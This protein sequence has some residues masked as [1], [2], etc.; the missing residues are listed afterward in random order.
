[1]NSKFI[2]LLQRANGWKLWTG[3]MLVALLTVEVIVALL[4][5]LFYG[6]VVSE[7]L[8]E[9][10]VATAIVEP[11]HLAFM[12]YLLGEFSKSQ[13]H[14]LES[15]VAYA[16]QRFRVAVEISQLN[17]WEMNLVTNEI[18]Y[19]DEGLR[20]LGIQ[21][22]H[23]PHDMQSWLAFVHPE[24]RASLMAQFQHALQPGSA[25][26]DFEY[27]IAHPGGLWGWA[28]TR[29]E[30]AKRDAA[31]NPLWAVGSTLNVTTRKNAEIAL[32]EE[33]NRFEIIFNNTPELMLI[34]RLSDGCIT[35]ANDAA[36]RASGYSREE[37]IGNTTVNLGV[38]QR[39][40][41]RQRM[42]D[43][44]NQTGHCHNIE[45]E[46][47]AKNGQVFIGSV[48]AVVT[49]LDGVPHIVSTVRDVTERKR[50]ETELQRSETLL[51]STLESTDEGILMIAQDGHV[52]SANKRFMELWRVPKYLVDTG[53]DDLL[54]AHVLEQL[55]DP[56]AFLHQVRRL[57]N[58]YEEA[59]DVLHF[60][61][62]RV[63]ARFTRALSVDEESGRIWCFKDITEEARTQ[64]ALVEREEMFRSIFAQASDGIWL[65]DPEDKRIIEFNDAACADLGYSRAE[66]AKF[67]IK[68]IQ[69]EY[70]N[71][72]IEQVSQ[73]ILEAGGLQFDTLH[74]HKNGSTRVVQVSSKPIRLHGKQY[75]VSLVSD[76]TE[77]KRHEELLRANEQKM[78]TILDNVDAFIYLK[79]IQ[80]NYLFANRRVRELWQV[81]MPDIVGYG[82][83]KFFDAATAANIRNND[84]RV[85]QGGEILKAEE[86]NTVPATGKTFTYLSTKLPLRNEDGSI[87]ALCGI[88]T[89]I[90]ERIEAE[91]TLRESES[92][93]HRA[94]DA[95]QMGVWEFDFVARKLYWSEEIFRHL[96]LAHVEPSPE[97]LRTLIHP[98]DND[99]RQQAMSKAV[100]ERAAYFAVYRL[101]VNGKTYWTE[102]RGELQYDA[103]GNPLKMIGTAQDITARKNIEQALAE[104]EASLRA[105][106][107]VAGLGTYS[108]DIQTGVWKSSAVLDQLLGIDA[109]Y[110]HSVTGWENLIHAEDRAMMHDYFLHEVIGKKSDFQ[111]EYRIVR[112]ADNVVRWVFGLGRLE[113][114]KAG[115]PSKMFGT[116]QDITARK[117]TEA[118]LLIAATAF[119][120]QEG[121]MVTD[122]HKNILKVNAAFTAI[123][124]YGAE[125]VIGKNP[126]MLASGLQDKNFYKAMWDS[127][128][129]HG[130]WKGELLNR[131]KSGEIYPELLMITAVKDKAGKVSHYV[132]AQSDNS[133]RQMVMEQLRSAAVNLEAVNRQV[134][135]ERALLAQRVEERTSQLRYANRAKDSFLATM[136]HEI[137]TPLGGLLGMMELL[138]MS[139]L[140][141]EQ[142]QMLT[143][144]RQSG[145]SLLRIVDD[146]LD[147]S[148]IEA[149]KL[150][151]APQVASVE[152]M[153]K[154]VVNTYA[155]L[156]AAKGV[157]LKLDIQPGGN[158]H[159]YFDALR[160]SQ[161]LNNFTSNA[162]KFT[163]RGTVLIKLDWLGG[164]HG[165]DT[166]RFSVKDNGIGIA[167]EQQERLFHHYEQASA[168][169]ARMYGGTGLGL[170]ICRSLADLL[171]G[172]I[173]V[174]S[175][176]N[177]GST[178]SFSISLPVANVA[179]DN[180]IAPLAQTEPFAPLITKGQKVSVLVVDDHPMNRMLLK[181]QLALLGLGVEVSA[182]G[183]EAL[184]LW[185][186][187]KYD[188]IITDCHMPEMDGYELTRRIRQ[189]E[190]ET[191]ATR[192][193]IIAW[194]A[195]ALA[196]E[197]ANCQQAGMDDL[198]TKPTELS[199]LK[200]MLSKW[201]GKLMDTATPDVDAQPAAGEPP[202]APAIVTLDMN[203][204]RKIS[205]RH[206]AQVELLSEFNKENRI[207]IA[208]LKTALQVGDEVAAARNAHRVK[209]ASRMVGAL[210][211][212]EIC[213]RIEQLAKQEDMA[214]ARA[215]AENSLDEVMRNLE[216]AIE[217]IIRMP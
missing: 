216:A 6:H 86:T 58:S 212:E 54:L 146:I 215:A 168:D 82:D 162:I 167:P 21:A 171:G 70:D 67:S 147:W 46:V 177:A 207:D 204:L 107:R 94:L 25:N 101:L 110:E 92:R 10:L 139:H 103:Q 88:S 66:F 5:V 132:G 197:V 7:D 78:L 8:I 41:D 124:G 126:R 144:A 153:L 123:T 203:V 17:V 34:S 65:I 31:G 109:R 75:L 122:A 45:V 157:E 200:A 185:Q 161:I 155:Q 96:G 12:I 76:I 191:S 91:H 2:A 26:F 13:I 141:I 11:T 159:H 149:K 73:K 106:Q 193:P 79:D 59:R 208:N 108:L 143:A 184:S 38:W 213:T 192:L 133:E 24:D 130:V 129:T 164:Y 47:T 39:A 199:A 36:V 198:M 32:Q 117:E 173:E 136:S 180:T 52:L 28:H 87:Y 169:T 63:F 174:E 18:I 53:K 1:M 74:K 217:K 62:G 43:A 81:E 211:L 61:D 98:D 77:R 40:E 85:L 131:R 165:F 121:L 210:Q 64:T 4:D 105:S 186:A 128:N 22:D 150:V 152:D 44:L 30:I 99:I 68:D 55:V 196:D 9:G 51:R 84:C 37:I 176:P 89:D 205:V 80:G 134:E 120:S 194:T 158:S 113:W 3:V 125:E 163:E 20:V 183:G 178:F 137:R 49:S 170:S 156:A 100:S 14:T 69:A 90:T 140:D 71:Q 72:Q 202:V 188:L 93:L 115:N 83:E 175:A 116:I 148:K 119:E 214:N 195:N 35:H 60:K 181:Q 42:L 182:D 50:L 145:K 179:R 111:K 57:Y 142:H 23:A 29:G 95:A 187:G 15:D 33:K 19:D 190:R 48:S 114:D 189:A 135:E 118:Q 112:H 206:D 154:G 172:T 102:D 104:S 16:N 138:S 151:L 97:F 160:V 209:G 27:R 201:L 127:I 166:V 56:E